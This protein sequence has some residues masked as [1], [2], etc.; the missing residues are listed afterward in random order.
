M[1]AVRNSP[2]RA[3]FGHALGA[4]DVLKADKSS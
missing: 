4:S 2:V 1:G 3:Q